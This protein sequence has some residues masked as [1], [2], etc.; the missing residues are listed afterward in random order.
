MIFTM[1]PEYFQI[2]QDTHCRRE[3]ARGAEKEDAGFSDLFW[4]L[5]RVSEC[6]L[7]LRE[8][9]QGAG[10]DLGGASVSPQGPA[11][12]FLRPLLR[13]QLGRAKGS[14]VASP[15]P[16]LHSHAGLGF[17]RPCS[18][19]RASPWPSGN[20]FW[21]RW[22]PTLP[23]NPA[24][25][26]PPEPQ[27]CAVPRGVIRPGTDVS[28]PGAGSR[29][30]AQGFPHPP[31]PNSSRPAVSAPHRGFALAP[32]PGPFPTP[33][34]DPRLLPT[35]RPAPAPAEYLL[36]GPSPPRRGSSPSPGSR[37]PRPRS[38]P[39]TP[40]GRAAL[41]RCRIGHRLHQSRARGSAE[42]QPPPP[43]DPP[44]PLPVPPLSPRR[45]GPRHHPPPAPSSF[46]SCSV[47]P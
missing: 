15:P 17:D 25:R 2:N 30:A 26:H 9:A 18:V 20:G 46:P 11:R 47:L 31:P 21:T 6:A 22:P 4:R 12:P 45:P 3:R 16:P 14:S 5:R 10:S 35:Y 29:E 33:R 8:R 23:P 42:Q 13:G 38:P 37:V 32:H 7:P 43:P 41:S 28:G 19:P 1:S 36:L 24:S 44:R 39:D 40:P 27:C 34:N